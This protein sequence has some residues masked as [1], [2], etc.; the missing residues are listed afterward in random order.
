MTW[1]SAIF[2][3]QGE[4][5]TKTSKRKASQ[6]GFIQFIRFQKKKK[7]L[8]HKAFLWCLNCH[9]SSQNVE[10]KQHNSYR[11]FQTLFYSYATH[12]TEKRNVFPSHQGQVY[13]IMEKI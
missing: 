10:K 8:N 13:K 4:K 3:R 1:Q 2:D 12:G 9:R 11:M 7:G 5:V 6:S